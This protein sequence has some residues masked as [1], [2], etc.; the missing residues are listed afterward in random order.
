MCGTG[1]A[2]NPYVTLEL[3]WPEEGDTKMKFLRIL[4]KIMTSTRS[5]KTDDVGRGETAAMVYGDDVYIVLLHDRALRQLALAESRR[6][7]YRRDAGWPF[8]R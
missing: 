7:D 1:I 3:P 8:I 6:V 2:I 5:M 4:K